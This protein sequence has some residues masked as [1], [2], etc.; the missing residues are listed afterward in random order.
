MS[1]GRLQMPDAQSPD[2]HLLV[3]NNEARRGDLLREE[4]RTEHKKSPSEQVVQTENPTGKLRR[5]SRERPCRKPFGELNAD[6][7]PESRVTRSSS[8]GRLVG[9]SDTWQPVP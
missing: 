6:L 9:F 2:S 1:A 4:L 3:N 7:D 5:C 8:L